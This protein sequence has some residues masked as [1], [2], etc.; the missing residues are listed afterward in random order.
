VSEPQKYDTIYKK[1]FA[2]FPTKVRERGAQV[3]VIWLR[4]YYE[5]RIYVENDWVKGWAIFRSVRPFPERSHLRVI[6]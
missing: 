3:I 2:W 1:K 4:T 5:K 6:K